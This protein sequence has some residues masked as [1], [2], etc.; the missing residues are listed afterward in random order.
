MAEPNVGWIPRRYPR[1]RVSMASLL[2]T[3]RAMGVICAIAHGDCVEDYDRA[4]SVDLF[5]VASSKEAMKV[6]SSWL[7]KMAQRYERD[8]GKALNFTVVSVDELGDY[9]PSELDEVMEGGIHL[10]GD[11]DKWLIRR[12]LRQKYMLITY[13][14]GFMRVR[15]RLE[16]RDRLFGREI[17]MV[18][19]PS[20]YKMKEEGL[21]DKV[22]GLRV[23]ERSFIVPRDRAKEIMDELDK[24]GV[25][26]FAREVELSQEDIRHIK[27]RST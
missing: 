4:G 17:L 13:D 27:S 12:N 3:L 2:R 19:G 9:T 20:A 8:V 7:S 10:M 14:V 25:R 26:Y 24:A 15:R 16:L 23:G 11:I 22:G 1:A 6:I 18:H 5:L 21:V